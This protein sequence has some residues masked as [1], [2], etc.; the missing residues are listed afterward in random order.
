M[1]NHIIVIRKKERMSRPNWRKG[2]LPE[3]SA[4]SSSGGG[5]SQRTTDIVRAIPTPSRTSSVTTDVG[6]NPQDST[7]I[8]FFDICVDFSTACAEV[9]P[10]DEV[11]KIQAARISSKK[12]TKEKQ[13]E[14]L[15]LAKLFHS[16]FV[17]HYSLIV[18]KKPEFF[19]LPIEGLVSVNAS[20]KFASSPEDV[21]ET[22]WEYLKSLVQY[23]G[24][25]DM[26]SKCPQKMLDSISGV[27]GG[28][29][30]KLQSGEL[31]PSNLN[32]IALG[33]MMMQQ[34]STE[35]LE[36]FGKAIMEGGN[37]DSMMSIMQS[38]MGAGGIPGMGM[39]G[40]DMNAVMS[41]L[42]SQ[43]K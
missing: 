2:K 37:M 32:P 30:A 11:M 39:G 23:A 16:T 22:V 40:M 31:D 4:S 18:S 8:V 15:N 9:W 29:I 19:A 27:A 41:M 6:A 35:D 36:G 20:A 28:L 14:G 42:N 12:S 21:R 7:A 43:R 5:G 38:T 1:F 3:S 24:M 33:Q 13:E 25:V 26:Y 17:D 10:S 34:M